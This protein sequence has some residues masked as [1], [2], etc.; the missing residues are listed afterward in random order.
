MLERPADIQTSGMRTGA[1]RADRRVADEGHAAIVHDLN[2]FLTPIVWVLASLQERHS[3]SSMQRQRIE[4]AIACADR[5]R[6][7]VRQLSDIG[8]SRQLDFTLVRVSEM[9]VELEK[10]FLCA[11]GPRIKL[12]FDTTPALPV[13]RI[14]RERIERALLNLI[15]N[16]RDAMPDGGTVTV[17]ARIEL[18]TA[19]QPRQGEIR[20]RISICDTGTGM[21]AVTLRQAATPFFSTKPNGSGLG[22]AATRDL[23]ERL[24]GDMKITSALGIGTSIDIWLPVA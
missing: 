15:I 11:L 24:Y 7:L 3:D 14:D 13:V 19:A 2:N 16:A 9:L 17:C 10:V 23:I 4:G 12:V 5:A 6:S 8:A 18:R 1:E 20:L 22:L 21:D